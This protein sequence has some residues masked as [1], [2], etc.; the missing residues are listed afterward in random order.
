MA[1]AARAATK[2]GLVLARRASAEQD[3]A[4]KNFL[5]FSQTQKME[6]AQGRIKEIPTWKISWY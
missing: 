5:V 6:K 1:H 2:I 4:L 3:R